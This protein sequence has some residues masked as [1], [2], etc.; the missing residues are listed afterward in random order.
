[1]QNNSLGEAAAFNPKSNIVGSA[2][3]NSNKRKAGKSSS[4]KHTV[5]GGEAGLSEDERKKQLRRERNKEAAARCRKRRMD[6]TSS[7]QDEVDKLEA[8]RNEMQREMYGLEA[9]HERL[10]A[11]LTD[12][13][14]SCKKDSASKS[15]PSPSPSKQT[16][17]SKT[18]TS[19]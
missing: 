17:F 1:M 14:K 15:S 13:A 7:L 11:I 6:L 16:K 9:E 8:V 2:K 10:K 5:I 19:S 4:T 3:K 12:H 18:K